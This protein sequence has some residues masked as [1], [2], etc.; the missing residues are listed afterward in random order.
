MDMRRPLLQITDLHRS[1]LI[2]SLV[3]HMPIRLLLTAGKNRRNRVASAVMSV[4][5]G[6]FQAAD[7]S[8][9]PVVAVLIVEMAGPLI[10]RTDQRAGFRIAGGSMT[11]ARRFRE[12][13]DQGSGRGKAAVCV[14]VRL[15]LGNRTE[16]LALLRRIA[17]FTMGMELLITAVRMDMRLDLGQRTYQPA[18]SS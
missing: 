13:T 14:Q 2:A 9:G 10:Q 7:D 15:A 1:V 4:P 12:G 3:M 6:L 18:P 17:A 8:A 5:L 11:V 16:Q